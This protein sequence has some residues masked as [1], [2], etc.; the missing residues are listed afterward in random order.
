MKKWIIIV[1]VSLLLAGCST[2]PDPLQEELSSAADLTLTSPAFAAGESIPLRYTCDGED[3]SPALQWAD[4]PEG[5]QSFALVMDDPDAPAGT[6]VHWVLYN[7]PADA[8]ALPENIPGGETLPDG[9]LHGRN[10]WRDFGYGGPCP[11]TGT[12]SYVFKL[13]ALDTLLQAEPGLTKKALLEAM[14]GHVLAYGE[15]IGAYSR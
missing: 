3:T 9:G 13:Y 7:L 11:P 14:E 4:P 10:G 1:L 12:H 2:S 15:L 6:W 5:T 8:R